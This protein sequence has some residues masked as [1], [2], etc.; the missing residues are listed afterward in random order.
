MRQAFYE[1]KTI[2]RNLLHLQELFALINNYNF[3]FTIF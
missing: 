1:Q 2:I 3:Y